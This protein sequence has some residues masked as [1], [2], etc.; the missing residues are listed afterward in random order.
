MGVDLSGDVQ[1][2][3]CLYA[4]FLWNSWDGFPDRDK[5]YNWWGGF[6]GVDYV[7]SD[8]WTFSGLYNYADADDLSDTDTV[9]E[10]IDVNSLSLTASYYFMRNV[11]AIAEVNVDFLG[12]DSREGTYYTGHLTKED[13]ILFGFDASF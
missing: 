9:Y 2:K 11:K 5:D 3:T 7:A 8:Y 6:P 4:Q 1:G 13:Y 12:K 10:G